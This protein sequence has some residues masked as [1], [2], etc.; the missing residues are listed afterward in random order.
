VRR[1]AGL[2]VLRGVAILLVM[3]RHAFPDVF[4]G[5]GVVGVVVFFTLSGC[6]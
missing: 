3:L 5:A 6:H 1:T 2:D 4:P